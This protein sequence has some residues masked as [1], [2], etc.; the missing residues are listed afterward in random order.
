MRMGER[1]KLNDTVVSVIA[2]AEQDGRTC[3]S[4]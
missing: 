4:S 2:A 3:L 1:E